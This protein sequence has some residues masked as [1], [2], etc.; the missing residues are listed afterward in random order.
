MRLNKYLSFVGFCSRREADRLIDGGHIAVNGEKAVLGLDVEDGDLVTCDGKIV[1]G[2]DRKVILLFNKP[3]GVVCTSS[4]KEKNNIIDYINYPVRVYNAGR[5]DKDSRGLIILTNQGD[6]VND[7]GRARNYH[8][9]EYVVKVDHKVTDGFIKK[10]EQGI[11]LPELNVKTR[12]ARAFA[13][14]YNEF[15]IIL[16]E[17]LNREIRRICESEHYY[18]HDLRRIRIMNLKIDGIEEGKYRKIR[19]DEEK[20]LYRLLKT[21]GGDRK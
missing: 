17:G 11:F 16:T 19:P 13:T 20:E 18:V 1:K 4:A 2:P 7:L 9:K 8:E 15:H 6:L 21:S 10:I 3:K 5:L 12:P 14:A